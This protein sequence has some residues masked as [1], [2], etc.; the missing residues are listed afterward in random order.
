MIIIIKAKL[1]RKM[2]TD[3]TA[4]VNDLLSSFSRARKIKW[5]SFLLT[6][7]STLLKRKS[8]IS[9]ALIG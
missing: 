4:M 6:K 9:F 5:P 8:I 7:G 1:T 2:L 3:I